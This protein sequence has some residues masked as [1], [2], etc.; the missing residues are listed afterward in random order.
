[1]FLLNKIKKYI[2]CFTTML[3]TVQTVLLNHFVDHFLS[4]HCVGTD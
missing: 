3:F 4:A 2:K 1:M